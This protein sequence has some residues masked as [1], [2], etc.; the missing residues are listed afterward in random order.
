MNCTGIS[1]IS[2]VNCPF[3]IKAKEFFSTYN[4]PYTEINLDPTDKN[5][6]PKRNFSFNKWNHYS[7]PIIYIDNVKIGGYNDL[8]R[9]YETN[10][11]HFLLLDKCDFQ[12]EYDF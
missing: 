4:L 3:C 6:I 12:L 1:I 5:Y 11:L 10:K 8:I 9:S 7:F 2:K